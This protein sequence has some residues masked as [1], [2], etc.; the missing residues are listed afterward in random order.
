MKTILI[1][2]GTDGTGKGIAMHFLKKGDRV[3]VVG[4]SSIKGDNFYNEAKSLGLENRAIFIQANLSLVKENQ[5]V[6]KKIKDRFKA[7]DM[8]I[9]CASTQKYRENYLETEEGFEFTFA[10]NYLS[11]HILSF[12]L[13][14]LLEKSTN[15]VIMNVCAPGMKGTVNWDDL[16]HK[17]NFNSDKAKFHGSRLNDLLGVYF[18]QNDTVDKIK[19]I[20][21]NP[22]AVQT[23][24]ALNV[25]DKPIKNLITKLMYKLIGKPVDK[26]IIPMINLLENPPKMYLSAFKQYKEVD[27]NMKTYNKGNAKK[28]F[29]ITSRL[30]EKYDI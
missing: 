5:R 10:L 17:D 9:L 14:E 30:L 1:T 8:L 29:K 15:P 2:G 24:G 19:Y 16:Q 20:L 26:A 18:N 4:S 22:W 27:L 25:Y 7:L 28:L 11:R 13:K 23:P 12:G 6:I 3:I 21:F